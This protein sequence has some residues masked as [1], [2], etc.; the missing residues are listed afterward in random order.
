MRLIFFNCFAFNPPG[1]QVRRLQCV[2]LMQ[3]SSYLL[4]TRR[5]MKM[6]KSCSSFLS[7]CSSLFPRLTHRSIVRGRR[8]RSRAGGAGAGHAVESVVLQLTQVYIYIYVCVFVVFDCPIISHQAGRPVSKRSFNASDDEDAPAAADQQPAV[9][10]PLDHACLYFNA[11][12]LMQRCSPVTAR[13][14]N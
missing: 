14:L 9:R 8:P 13:S 6:A 2:L 7:R 1:T 5:H 4:T 12:F 11:G 3:M 10:S